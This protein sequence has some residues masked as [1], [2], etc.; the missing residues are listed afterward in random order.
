MKNFGTV[1]SQN[2]MYIMGTIVGLL[3]YY[4]IVFGIRRIVLYIG[5]GGIENDTIKI[6]KPVK[7]GKVVY[8]APAPAQNQGVG[9]GLLLLIILIIYIA[10]YSATPKS[11]SSSISIPYNLIPNKV[12]TCIPT[13]CG[14]ARFSNCTAK[15]YNNVDDCR[16][17][18]MSMC[19]S[20][21]CRQCP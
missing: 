12:V 21:M 10:S 5:F 2:N 13:G 3:L 9:L 17:A 20:F 6:P 15:C 11:S 14:N 16:K 19:G 4:V 1:V 7:G 8:V 18:S